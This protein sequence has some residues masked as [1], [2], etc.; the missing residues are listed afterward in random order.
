MHVQDH[1]WRLADMRRSGASGLAALAQ[2]AT[3]L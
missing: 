1:Q 2:L 3:Q